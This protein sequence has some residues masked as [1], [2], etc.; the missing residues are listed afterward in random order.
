MFA[1]L[2]LIFAAVALV[3]SAF[4][5]LPLIRRSREDA[6]RRPLLAVGAGLGVAALGLGFYAALGQPD[7]AISAL[8]GP[9]ADNYP[10]LIATLTRQMRERP[11]DLQGWALLGRGYMVVGNPG[12]AAKAL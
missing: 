6:K 2:I 12:E 7:L 8:R 1:V 3:A 10:A 4:V 9:G 5:V 11:G